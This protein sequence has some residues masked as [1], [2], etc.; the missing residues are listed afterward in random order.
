MKGRFISP[1]PLAGTL[2]QCALFI[3]AFVLLVIAFATTPI[4]CRGT[5]VHLPQL[6]G[7]D[8]IPSSPNQLVV[9]V[10]RDGTIFIDTKW[11]TEPAFG[12]KLAELQEARPHIE[13]LVRADATL[14]VGSV[15]GVLRAVQGAGFRRVLLVGF[16]GYPYQLIWPK[17]NAT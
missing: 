2:L 14:S 15:R 7:G 10:Q 6:T 8:P 13:I 16:E 17:P 9:T 5:S 12:A 11:Y 3:P 1:E 4:I